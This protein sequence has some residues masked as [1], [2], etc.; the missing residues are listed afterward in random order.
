MRIIQTP[1]AERGLLLGADVPA[2]LQQPSLPLGLFVSFEATLV[3][4]RYQPQG[5]GGS[6]EGEGG[7][8]GPLGPRP[9]LLGGAAGGWA[10]RTRPGSTSSPAPEAHL[11]GPSRASPRGSP[12]VAGAAPAPPRAPLSLGSFCVIYFLRRVCIIFFIAVA[13]AA[14]GGLGFYFSGGRGWGAISSLC[15]S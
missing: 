3:R 12:P 4:S 15:L 6:H 13:A 10:G 2:G 9:E 11:S 5:E 1:K 8:T 7:A 14:V